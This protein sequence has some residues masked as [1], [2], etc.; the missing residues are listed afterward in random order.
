MQSNVPIPDPRYWGPQFWFTM[1]TVAFFYPDTPNQT[2]MAHAR[3]FYSS[4]QSLLPCPGCAAH[5]SRMLERYPIDRSLES[6][7]TLIAW[8][9]KIH[10]EV[11][12]R[13]GK[14]IVTLSEYMTETHKPFA[15]PR[16]FTVLRIIALTCLAF[17]VLF[18]ARWKFSRHAPTTVN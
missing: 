16:D 5:Y 11:N 18:C 14:P 13:L 6:R 8:V 2:E 9:N 7:E 3:D 12:R 15:P 4:L 1:H 17:F 10:N